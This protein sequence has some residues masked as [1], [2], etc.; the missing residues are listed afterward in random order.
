LFEKKRGKMPGEEIAQAGARIAIQLAA[1]GSEYYKTKVT[2]RKTVMPTNRRQFF[3]TVGT[4]AAATLVADAGVENRALAATPGIVGRPGKSQIIFNLEGTSAGRLNDAA[5]GE[6]FSEVI[7]EPVD[8]TGVVPKHLGQT[9]YNDLTVVF[10]AGMSAPFYALITSFLDRVDTAFDGSISFLSIQL[11]EVLRLDFTE[12]V[13]EEF[14][15]PALEGGSKE[16]GSFTLMLDLG[17]SARVAGDLGVKTVANGKNWKRSNFRITIDGLSLTKTS[18][19]DAL[20]VQRR[21][22]RRGTVIEASPLEIPD[23]IVHVPTVDAAPIF[24]WYD[25]AVIGGIPTERNGKIEILAANQQDVLFTLDLFNLGIYSAALDDSTDA[26]VARVVA[27]MY[28]ERM[29]FT[30]APAAIA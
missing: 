12:A 10:D 28:C 19:I 6:A 11:K 29:K 23:I 17:S 18:R 3:K 27:K 20:T 8:A 4:T 26:P 30:A 9:L 21:I 2:R 7:Q 16:A 13:I 5:G 14:H 24:A 15:L 25:A 1:L 22:S